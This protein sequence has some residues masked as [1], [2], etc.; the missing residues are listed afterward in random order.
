AQAEPSPEARPARVTPVAKTIAARQ[1]LDLTALAG[2]GVG[3]A[4]IKR[5][6]VAL[7]DDSSRAPEG[8]FCVA[9]QMGNRLAATERVIT[10][11]APNGNGAAPAP[12]QPSPPAAQ[13]PA[14]P[15]DPR[16]PTL[17]PLTAMRRSIAEHMVRSKATSPHAT[18]AIEAD[19]SAVAAVRA[20]LR[21]GYRR[22]GVELTFTAC[23]ALAALR[24]LRG[25][26]ALNAS[27]HGEELARLARVQLGIAVAT[28]TGLVVPVVRDAAELSLQGLARSVNDLAERGKTGQLRPDELRGG[29]FTVT[30]PGAGAIRF[31]IPVIPQPQAAILG[32]GTIEKRVVAREIDGADQVVIRPLTTLTLSYDAR[33][34]GDHEADAFIAEVRAQLETF[35]EA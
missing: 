8:G 13:A 19:L 35:R 14:A 33:L 11:P 7:L 12:A 16:R 1:G 30:N 20:R 23:I 28:P 5:D 3:G 17:V 10:V 21:E 25:H 26:P 15:V 24:A 32:V 22:R 29:T 34:V 4:I 31:G 6:V 2:S 18:T 27:W 9:E